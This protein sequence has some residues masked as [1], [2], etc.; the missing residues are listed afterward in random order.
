VPYLPSALLIVLGLVVLVL[1]LSR[2]L[3]S[4][5][6]FG[7]ASATAR[8]EFGDR[9]GLIKARVAALGVAIAERRRIK[10]TRPHGGER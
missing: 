7:A 4:L 10:P 1:A 2:V 6:R 5:R 8:A 9:S 3:R